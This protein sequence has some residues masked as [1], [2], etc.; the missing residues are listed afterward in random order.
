M[1]LRHHWLLPLFFSL[2]HLIPP[3]IIAD[4]GIVGWYAWWLKSPLSIGRLPHTYKCKHT[5]RSTAWFLHI[6]AVAAHRARTQWRFYRKRWAAA[7]YFTSL[8]AHNGPM[9]TRPRAESR[10]L[11]LNAAPFRFTSSIEGAAY[12]LQNTSASGRLY[13]PYA[14]LHEAAACPH[15]QWKNILLSHCLYIYGICKFDFVVIIRILFASTLFDN[16][17]SDSRLSF[18]YLKAHFAFWWCRRF[19]R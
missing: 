11:A 4:F 16:R 10:L 15:A 9:R 12:W 7:G 19:D 18:R 1:R 3:M 8:S 2:R 5:R 17:W 6:G 13:A 14:R